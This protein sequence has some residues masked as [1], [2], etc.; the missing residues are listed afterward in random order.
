MKRFALCLICFVFVEPLQGQEK[1]KDDDVTATAK[2]LA[3]ERE[4]MA[5]NLQKLAAMLNGVLP[6]EKIG[7]AFELIWVE[8]TVRQ[9]QALEELQKVPENKRLAK[10]VWDDFENKSKGYFDAVAASEK[11]LGIVPKKGQTIGERDLT[12]LLRIM[13][14]NRIPEKK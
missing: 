2:V 12:T 8:N 1:P 13:I 7:I 14:I 4:K 9:Y 11:A 10:K 3:T 6:P 5:P